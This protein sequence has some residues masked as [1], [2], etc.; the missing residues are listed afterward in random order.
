MFRGQEAV[1]IYGGTLGELLC[2]KADQVTCSFLLLALLLLR[3]LVLLFLFLP[4][5]LLL[6]MF[7]LFFPLLGVSVCA[8]LAPQGVQVKVMVWS[9]KSSGAWVGDKGMMNTHDMETFNYFKDRANYRGS[10]LVVCALAPRCRILLGCFLY[11]C[12]VGLPKHLL[13]T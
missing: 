12:Y 5:L 9:E 3:L 1:D 10:N 7:L 8:V 11:E 2:R 4:F 13:P 6:I